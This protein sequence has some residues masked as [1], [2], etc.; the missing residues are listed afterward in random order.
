MV[1]YNLITNNGT[2]TGTEYTST[3]VKT[4]WNITET[5]S[6]GSNVT[7]LFQWN[8][9]DEGAS[10]NRASCYMSHYNGSSW[11][12]PG[13]SG[14]ASGSNPYTFTYSNYTGSFS[15]FGMGGSGGPL[16]V[17][18]LYFNAT[19]ESNLGQINWAT[20]SEIN[21][22]YFNIEKSP[23]GTNF[24]IIGKIYGAGNSQQILK[25]AFTDSNLLQGLNYY[26]L[27]QTDYDGKFSYSPVDV[28]SYSS[29]QKESVSLNI[30]P[31]PAFDFINIDIN[32]QTDLETPLRIIN[33][34]GKIVV[35]KNVTLIRGQNHL[36]I[37]LN[38]LSEGIYFIQFD[39]MTGVRST[40]FLLN[41]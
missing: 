9:T 2:R 23:D 33:I 27:K 22:D 29:E 1:A 19:N 11:E 6:G 21:N 15:P 41:K 20:A 12:S 25:Y 4:T 14:S 7:L 35:E 28:I 40:R 18:L 16:P 32:S 37:N 39:G 30:Y 38:E 8:G 13:A 34:F 24:K 17:K 3:V 10:F 36:D 5:V 26:R 31:V